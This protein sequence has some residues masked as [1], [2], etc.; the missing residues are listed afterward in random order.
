MGKLSSVQRSRKEKTLYLFSK[1]EQFMDQLY[2]EIKSFVKHCKFNRKRPAIRLNLTSDLD[3]RRFRKTIFDDFSS[4]QF[5]DYSKIFN[6]SCEWLDGKL[7]SN[8]HL[9]FSRSEKNEKECK[10]LLGRGMNVAVVFRNKFPT[11][12]WDY[13]VRTGDGHDLRFLE[14]GPC[15]IGLKAKN[16]A[17]KDITGFTVD[18]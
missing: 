13:E 10:E 9:T 17:K 18:V 5:Y 16:R 15:I 2:K 6:R 11:K 7:P 12:F 14:S 1:T 8:Y 4:V 3:F